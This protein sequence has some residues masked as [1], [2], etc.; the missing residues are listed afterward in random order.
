MLIP[1]EI[2]WQYIV[3][4]KAE[5]PQQL[6]LKGK[7]PQGVDLALAV[8]QIAAR[9]HAKYKLP[10]WCNT[11]F[12]VFPPTLSLEQCSSEW[13]ANYKRELLQGDSLID[14][15]G[16]F[17]IDCA[18]LAQNFKEVHYVERQEVLCEIAKHNFPRLQLSQIQVHHQDSIAFLQ[19]TAPVDCIFL[20][21]A[22]R[23][24]GKKQV[25]IS[26]CEPDAS[27]WSML[28][29]E[30]AKQV[31]IKLSPMLDI[32]LALRQLP[33][34]QEVHIIS[35]QNECKELLLKLNQS[36]KN[37]RTIHCINY[38]SDARIEQFSFTI[39]EEQA[40]SCSFTDEIGAYLYEPNASLLK[41]GAYKLLAKRMELNKLHPNT[42]LYTNNEKRV[43]F[44][45]RKFKVEAVIH[46]NKKE[47]RQGLAGITQANLTTR[48]FPASVTELRKRLKIKEGGEYYLFATTLNDKQKVV[49]KCR[50]C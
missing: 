46:F 3:K 23:A 38:R 28:L 44:P 42:H 4:N 25:A 33:Q 2:T 36:P 24:E 41:A 13:T 32:Q 26:D 1:N 40:T 48:N 9:Q 47:L 37:R 22:R 20:D 19:E 11:P 34:T 39:E 7:A 31:L 27:F 6:I 17:G 35:V 50:K 30:K 5:Q 21:P 18:F 43:D 8:Q 12:I 45:G 14:L 16:G 29:L 15:T 10:S 49:I